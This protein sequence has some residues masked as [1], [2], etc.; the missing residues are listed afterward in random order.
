MLVL[1]TDIRTAARIDGYL[2]DRLESSEQEISRTRTHELT[3]EGTGFTRVFPPL[4]VFDP[5]IDRENYVV[6]VSHAVFS[7]NFLDVLC[8]VC[9]FFVF[10]IFRSFVFLRV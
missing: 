9:T 3:I 10:C 5:H 7:R 4:I 1:V 2:V 8:L 6:K